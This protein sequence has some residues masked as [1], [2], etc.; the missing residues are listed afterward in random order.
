MDYI[1]NHVTYDQIRHAVGVSEVELSDSEIDS[2]GIEYQLQLETNAWLPST[3]DTD[4]IYSEGTD[5]AATR[6]QKLKYFS[7]SV[8]LKNYSAYLILIT[9]KLKFAK[10]ISDSD[11]SFERFDWEQERLL[12][13]L[14]AQANTAKDDFL[15]IIGEETSSYD[16]SIYAGKSEPSFDPI[17][18]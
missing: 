9:S 8:Y 18:G 4:T 11:N 6:E 7:F 3:V 17:T 14:I 16:T 1:G 5:P 2:S 13:H 10:K 15:S 12:Q